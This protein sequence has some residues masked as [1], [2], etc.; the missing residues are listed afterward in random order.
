MYR[1]AKDFVSG[2]VDRRSTAAGQQVNSSAE[3]LRTIAEQLRGD[4]FGRPLAEFV[5]RGAETLDEFGQYLQDSDSDRLLSDAEAFGRERPWAVVLAGLAIGLTASRLMKTAGMADDGAEFRYGSAATTRAAGS[6]AS[7]GTS[8]SGTSTTGTSTSGSPAP[9]SPGAS[10]SGTSSP[11]SSPPGPPSRGTSPSAP[12]PGTSSP[13]TASPGAAS[14][15]RSSSQPGQPR[16]GATTTQPNPGNPS[17]PRSPGS[18]ATSQGLPTSRSAPPPPGSGGTPKS[19]ASGNEPRNQGGA[20]STGADTPISSDAA[21][22]K[23][24]KNSDSDR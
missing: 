10:S 24:R 15:G 6:G 14:P 4:D 2:E 22:M 13:G 23:A 7:S 3:H 18:P 1:Q 20:A 19:Y 11:G 17:P 21:P 5:D 16:P 9:R 12:S 8:S